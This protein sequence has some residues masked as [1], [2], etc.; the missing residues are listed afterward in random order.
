MPDK[1]SWSHYI[2]ATSAGAYNAVIAER[3]GVDPATVGRWR[4]GAVDPKPRQV[5]AYA[6]AFELSPVQALVAAGYLDEDEL[7]LPTTPPRAY[8][9]NDFSTSELLEEALARV[10]HGEGYSYETRRGEPT[11]VAVDA[12]GN[13]IPLLAASTDEAG[14]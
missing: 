3:I 1:T 13:L 2:D 10:A 12:T 8:A 9:L 6:R 7:D 11:V 5:V 4:A 14:Q